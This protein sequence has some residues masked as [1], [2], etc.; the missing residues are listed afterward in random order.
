MSADLTHLPTGDTPWETAPGQTTG[1]TSINANRTPSDAP[2]QLQEIVPAPP[3]EAME[4]L[5]QSR[6]R[7]PLTYPKADEPFSHDLFRRPTGEYRGCPLWA[8]NAK[9]EKGPMIRQI[10]YLKEM[11]FGG[12]HM[13]VRTGLD[14][15]YMGEEFMNVVKTCVEVAEE[16]GMMA[17]LYDDDRWPSGVA[18]GKVIEKY[19]EHKGKHLL[20]TTTPYG[21]GQVGGCSPS[22]AAACRSENGRL[23]ARYGIRLN[24][25]DGTL[26]STR[27]L[28]HVPE[29]RELLAPDETIWY[30]YVETN[31]PSEWFNGQ[32]YVDTLSSAAMRK[33]VDMT[34]EKYKESVGDKFGTTVPCIFTDEPQ[35]ATKT[36]LS[37]PFAREDLFLPWTNDLPATFHKRYY[38]NLEHKRGTDHLIAS[39]PELFW[40][41]PGGHPSLLR[42][43]FHDHVC[44][45]FVYAF[46][47][48]LGAWCKSNNIHLNGHMM[49]EPTLE[50]QTHSL[51]EAMR[52]YRSQTL[53]GIDLLSDMVEYNTA[54][55]ASSVAR[56]NG[57]RGCMSEIYGC[58]HWYF[59]FEGHKGCGDWQA[60]LGVTFRVPHLAWVSMAGE[61]KRDYPA[62]INYQSPWYREYGYVEDHFARV[63]VAMTRG[64][65]VSRV[66]VVHPIESFWLVFGP[67]NDPGGQMADRDQKFKELTDWLLHG[68]IDFDFISESLL[69][70]QKVSVRGKTLLVG[71]CT[72]DAVILPN[73]LTIR[74]TTLSVLEKFAM[75]GGNVI[76][77]GSPPALVDA[78]YGLEPHLFGPGGAVQVSWNQHEILF[79]V[80]EFRELEIINRGSG[81]RAGA[82]L[83]QMRQ[84]GEERFIFI[85]NT[86]RTSGVDTDVLLRG[87]WEVELL[88]T[89]NGENTWLETILEEEFGTNCVSTTFG[90][91]FEGCESAL[92]RL[93][94]SKNRV[95]SCPRALYLPQ[96]FPRPSP[97]VPLTLHGVDLTEQGTKHSGQNVLMLDYARYLIYG[98]DSWS[99]VQEILALNNE[100]LD[101]L[102]LPRKGS[103]WRQPWTIS[104]VDREPKAY[105]NIA[106]QFMSDF[107]V[108][109]TTYLAIEL[110]EGAS[111]SLDGNQIAVNG[112][113]CSTEELSRE[114]G[115]WFVDESI[116]TIPICGNTIQRGM[117]T[118]QVGFPCGML[119]PIE[120]VY[121][122]GDFRVELAQHAGRGVLA[123][124][125]ITPWNGLTSWGDITA[126]GLPFYAGNVTYHCTFDLSAR[127][128]ATLSVPQFSSPVLTVEWGKRGDEKRGHI[129]FQPR[130]LDLGVLDAGVHGISITAYGNR[131]NAFGHIH[132]EDW[133]TTC[134]PDAWR[135]QPWAW[136]D[137]YR[138]KPIGIL[139]RP[140]VLLSEAGPDDGEPDTSGTPNTPGTPGACQW[141]L[142][143]RPAIFEGSGSP[144]RHRSPAPKLPRS[145]NTSGRSSRPGSPGSWVR[146]SPP[147]QP[148]ECLGTQGEQSDMDFFLELNVQVQDAR[149]KIHEVWE[150]L[151]TSEAER[152]E[153]A[154]AY[155]EVYSTTLLGVLRKEYARL[156]DLR[157]QRA[158]RTELKL[159]TQDG[160]T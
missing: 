97:R 27:L 74:S 85:C 53:P 103:A 57:I 133:M 12:F 86:D 156:Q 68:L 14:T 33:F 104:P 20:F 157:E 98:D 145:T 100:I 147:L 160:G 81:D 43:R 109:T 5:G 151:K 15:E 96:T 78:Q 54:K 106:F 16:M 84:D 146:I 125:K 46:M 117:N 153:F 45:R 148:M 107:D 110:P 89:L 66:A 21:Q 22:S 39:L 65:A 50:S 10:G 131:Y 49:E 92:L 119:T 127:S 101:R 111:I 36:K 121:L 23:L 42:Y 158:K 29:P 26:K 138:V 7:N 82:L 136:T 2:V 102:S 149:Q 52:C 95:I 13:H 116:S 48:Q 142:V 113:A 114:R 40:N 41:K 88:D 112:L 137:E 24:P 32:T 63:G 83:Y 59:T 130:A 159:E 69:P 34:H 60:A 93:V 37:D 58:T 129:A 152:R 47:D 134:W 87:A 44:E 108:P 150:S 18:G 17:C 155:C 124:A 77:A 62:S 143:S 91:T 64:R 141:E 6:P 71:E 28:S 35:F 73:L 3:T 1:M 31:P 126:M 11:G 38:A 80:E 118:L 94:P 128:R 135:T 105:V 99:H 90:Y 55:Q 75:A 30:A 132:A 25:N 154:P 8:W 115:D 79:S 76:V 140:T 61:A 19:P 9:L 72:Y 144:S 139:E 120:R 4:A 51:G 122:L 70:E 67:G 56:Q 123:R